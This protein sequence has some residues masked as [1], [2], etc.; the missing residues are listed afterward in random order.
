MKGIIAGVIT[1]ALI[2]FVI[3]PHIVAWMMNEVIP[4]TEKW[5]KLVTIGVWFCLLWVSLGFSFLISL[6]V[7]SIISAVFD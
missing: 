3:D 4:E 2:L 1:L 6:L 5:T 7:G